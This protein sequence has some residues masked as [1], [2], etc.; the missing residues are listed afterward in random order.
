MIQQKKKIGV[1]E[2]CPCGSGLKYQKCCGK[3]NIT[4]KMRPVPSPSEKIQM[5]IDTFGYLYEIENEDDKYKFIDVTHILNNMTYK[6]MQ[7]ENYNKKI[8]MVAEQTE[9]NKNVFDERLQSGDNSSNIIVMYRGSYRLFAYEDLPDVLPNICEMI[10]QMN[11][12]DIN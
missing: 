8:I 1:N 4:G 9:K 5:C 12:R 7:L 11:E 10:N 6:S 3:I 2:K